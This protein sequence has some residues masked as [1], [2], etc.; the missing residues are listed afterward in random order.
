MPLVLPIGREG[1]GEGLLGSGVDIEIEFVCT[2]LL[3][4]ELV[5]S[6]RDE[7]SAATVIK[8]RVDIEGECELIAGDFDIVGPVDLDPLVGTVKVDSLSGLAGDEFGPTH[9]MSGS[10]EAGLVDKGPGGFGYTHAHEIPDR[11]A[12][13]LGVLVDFIPVVIHSAATVTGD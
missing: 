10:V 12:H 11:T 2:L 1:C 5:A 6:L 4:A 7:E 8:P 13:E 9:Y 3:E